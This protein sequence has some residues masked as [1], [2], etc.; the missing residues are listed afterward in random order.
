M[1]K[2]L[3]VEDEEI[4]R[5]GLIFTTDFESLHCFVVGEASDGKEA[6]EKIHSL[7]PDIVI[8]DINMPIK[9][10]LEMIEDTLDCN[11]ATIIISGYD[12]FAYAKKA[13]KYGVCE[14]LLKPI[15]Q[16]D[17][18]DALKN[19]I[20]QQD[21]RTMHKQ[22]MKQREKIK[23]ITLLLV[24]EQAEENEL[25][26]KMM[27]YV[28]KHYMEK[29]VMQEIAEKLNYSESLLNHR[30]KQEMQCT[31]ND[32]L[33]RFRIQKSIEMM[34]SKKTS[35]QA[36]AGDCGFSDYKYFSIVFKKYISCSPKEFIR[37]L[38]TEYEQKD[39]KHI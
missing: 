3:I 33:N 32:Y 5:K 7:H 39:R 1:Y 4:I 8:T 26:N 13:L 34:K 24:H 28:A 25:I 37:I 12:D 16:K 22:M 11:Y 10:G 19:A 17:L 35:L 36:I 14:Y 6:I 20:R 27:K 18:E 31:F 38:T 15:K 2:V 9:N 30:F 23:D 21:M 29:I